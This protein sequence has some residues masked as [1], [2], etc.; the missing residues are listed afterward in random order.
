VE[1]GEMRLELSRAMTRG[2]GVVRDAQSL[3]SAL[4]ALRS[5]ALPVADSSLAASE[6]CNLAVVGEAVLSAAL[7]RE[8]SRGGHY[9]TD[10]PSTEPSFERR[11]AL[12]EVAT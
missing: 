9:R 10:Y 2:A 1:L 8:E 5:L 7:A 3:T 4:S 11:L 6:L 12:C